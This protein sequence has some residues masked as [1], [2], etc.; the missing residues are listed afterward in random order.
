ME[1]GRGGWRRVTRGGRCGVDG[2]VGETGAVRVWW[3]RDAKPDAQRT[4]A[5]RG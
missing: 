4:A 1:K 5:G 3:C 2:G